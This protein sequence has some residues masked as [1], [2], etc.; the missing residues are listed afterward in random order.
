[1]KRDYS[2]QL[3]VNLLLLV[4]FFSGG[5]LLLGETQERR[6]RTSLLAERLDTYAELVHS[7]L[8]EEISP[9]LSGLSWVGILPSELRLTLIDDSGRV[10]YDN[11][12]SP[13]EASLADNHSRRP[14]IVEAMQHGTGIDKRLSAST[15]QE[16]LYY[17][18][19]YDKCFVR[20]SLPYN[21]TVRNFYVAKSDHVFLYCILG[22]FTAMLFIIRYIT[23]RFGYSV[24][25]EKASSAEQ[26]RSHERVSSQ[27]NVSQLKQEMTSNVAHELR[28]PVSSIRGYLET[29][30][31]DVSISDTGRQFLQRAYR[32]A[33]V[34]SAL[35]QDMSTLTNIEEARKSFYSTSVELSGLLSGLILD[36]EERLNDRGIEVECIDL[37]GV[38][39]EGNDQ[40]VYTIFRNL[41]D[42]V[43]RHAGFGV[44]IFISKQEEDEYF[45]TLSFSDNGVGVMQEEQ[46]GHLFERFYRTDEGRVRDAGGSGLGLSIVKNTVQLLGGEITVRNHAGGGLQFLIR[47]PRYELR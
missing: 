15:R 5:I 39:V 21:S 35:I 40:M 38:K 8:P 1:M 34:L 47:L 14:E 18:K 9:A 7:I 43:V 41:I 44:H 24:K 3:F 20:V 31:T 26:G 22:I 33:L 45:H 4:S 6:H 12:L 28:T 46:L 19:R 11:S 13:L 27:R 17:A 32:Q 2:Q 10:V 25:K 37:E 16:Y 29:L 42:N 36:L 23:D 30:L